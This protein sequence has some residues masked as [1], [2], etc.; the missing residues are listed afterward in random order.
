MFPKRPMNFERIAAL[1]KGRRKSKGTASA[2]PDAAIEFP[3]PENASL[4]ARLR[5]DSKI[6]DPQKNPMG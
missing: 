4:F 5:E 1:V 2:R 6:A 3:H